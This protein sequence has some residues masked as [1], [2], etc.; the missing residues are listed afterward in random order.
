MIFALANPWR[1]VAKVHLRILAKVCESLRNHELRKLA[2]A[3]ETLRN[4]I[5]EFA[6]KLAT[7]CEIILAKAC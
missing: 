2:K 1:M 3:Y 7:A 5:C 6:R 4:Q